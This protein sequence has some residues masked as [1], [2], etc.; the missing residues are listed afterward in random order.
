MVDHIDKIILNCLTRDARMPLKE[1]G[2]ECNLS[3]TAVH[4]RINKL[5]QSGVIKGA[6]LLVDPEKLGFQTMSYVGI[7]LEKAGMYDKVKQELETFPEVVECSYTTGDY[8]ML[9]KVYCR[10]NRHLME[11]LSQRIQVLDSVSRTDTLICLD[12]SFERPL[13]IQ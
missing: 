11:L 13:T 6:K 8:S 10:D 9:I 4:Q 12:H 1:I 2:L 7:F 5:E 3:A